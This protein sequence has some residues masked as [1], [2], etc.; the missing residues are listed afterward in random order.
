MSFQEV[1]TSGV[2]LVVGRSI[3]GSLIDIESGGPALSHY[4]V[5]LCLTVIQLLDG[6][7]SVLKIEI[8]TSGYLSRL[9]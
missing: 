1:N 4:K 5:C 2:N 3:I 6:F 7:F 8:K 9:C